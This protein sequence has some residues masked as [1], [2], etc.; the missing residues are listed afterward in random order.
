MEAACQ[1]KLNHGLHPKQFIKDTLKDIP[2]GTS[3]ALEGKHPEGT[4]LVAI[5][6]RCNLKV[7]LYFVI[8]KNAGSAKA[9]KLH[10]MKFSDMHNNVHACLVDRPRIASKFFKRLNYTDKHN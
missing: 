9:G 10:E 7:T 8:T 6:Y 5:G 2:S 3:I 4:E 1:I